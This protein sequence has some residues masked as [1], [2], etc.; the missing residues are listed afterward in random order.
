VII[1]SL[2]DPGVVSVTTKAS[3]F[4]PGA[5]VKPGRITTRPEITA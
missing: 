1:P 5:T 4:A 2:A 3:S